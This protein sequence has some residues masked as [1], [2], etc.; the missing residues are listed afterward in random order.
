MGSGW[1]SAAHLA[2]HT[3]SSN[4][5]FVSLAPRSSTRCFST[6]R[7]RA[8]RRSARRR[9]WRSVRTPSVSVASCSCSCVTRHRR[10][11]TSA[12]W[13]GV[14]TLM[15]LWPELGRGL[16][17][18]GHTLVD[19]S[20]VLSSHAGFGSS[21]GSVGCAS[22]LC[23]NLLLRE[24]SRVPGWAWGDRAGSDLE[25]EKDWTGIGR[26][27]R[28]GFVNLSLIGGFNKGDGK[29]A[30]LKSDTRHRKRRVGKFDVACG[31]FFSLC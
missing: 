20:V 5:S 7:W 14:C 2:A 9:P 6:V 8:W 26:S 12:D 1:E 10:P 22:W 4:I 3:S 18:L 23:G 19:Q 16:V 28:Y 15:L 21:F 17:Q 27:W 30:P 25:G 31:K 29:F 24:D 13:S 11:A